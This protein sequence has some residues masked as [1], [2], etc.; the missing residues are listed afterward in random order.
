M[1]TKC[2]TRIYQLH[3]SMTLSPIL[4]SSVCIL[5]HMESSSARF[6]SSLHF[7]YFLGQNFN[8][9]YR[10]LHVSAWICW[11]PL[12][13][14]SKNQPLSQPTCISMITMKNP[15]LKFTDPNSRSPKVNHQF[16]PHFSYH[17]IDMSA[18]CGLHQD[19][20]SKRI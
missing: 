15:Q 17:L 8:I 16:I 5:N 9:C 11:T 13:K 3:L 2:I 18:T 7:F 1:K 4:C 19:S 14:K 12:K 10:E 6:Q 20:Q